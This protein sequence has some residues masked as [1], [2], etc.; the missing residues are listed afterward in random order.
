MMF[1]VVETLPPYACKPY[2]L[3]SWFMRQARLMN[4]RLLSL[5]AHCCEFDE[6]PG[7]DPDITTLEPTAWMLEPELR[8][9]MRE[10]EMA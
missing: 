7:Y 5:Y 8:D 2:A 1:I 9:A 3:S 4:D 6:W 10:E